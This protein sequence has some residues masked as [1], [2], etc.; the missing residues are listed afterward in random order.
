M[1][2]WTVTS[3]WS[4]HKQY[5]EERNIATTLS[6]FPSKLMENFGQVPAA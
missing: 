6:N 4:Q 2:F 3:H 1:D 5:K